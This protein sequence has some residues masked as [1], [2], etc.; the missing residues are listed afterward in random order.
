MEIAGAAAIQAPQNNREPDQALGQLTEDFDN[1]LN[2]LTTQLQNQD[3]LD[4]L[5]SNE[6]TNQLVQFSQVEQQ[7]NS[8]SKLDQ[9]ISLQGSNASQAGLGY[10]GLDV[11]YKGNTFTHEGGA[12]EIDYVLPETAGQTQISILDENGSVV[13]SSPGETRAGQHTLEWDGNDI[14]GFPVG[15][16]EYSIAIGSIRPDGSSIPNVKTI[17]PGHVDGFETDGEGNVAL[18]VGGSRILI[19]DVITA[20]QPESDNTEEQGT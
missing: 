4:P 2:L 6:F 5:K 11:T 12:T 19:S 7:I 9:L 10:I 20:T 3:P 16:G 13:F 15:P 17:V 18:L 14:Q 1:F 8:N